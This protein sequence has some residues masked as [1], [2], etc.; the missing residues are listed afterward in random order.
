MR[1]KPFEDLRRLKVDRRRTVTFSENAAGSAFFING[2]RFSHHRIDERVKLGAVEEWTIRNIS[3]EQHPFHI[4]QGDFQVT[5]INGRPVSAH[6]LQDTV[7]LPQHGSV[8]MRM[9][10]KIA[11]TF[12]FH[13]HILAHEDA[14]MMAVVRVA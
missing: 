14:G 6:G 10:F 9:H 13:C 4:H 3:G 12:V 1:I 2:R 8:T 11:G 7:P 5:K